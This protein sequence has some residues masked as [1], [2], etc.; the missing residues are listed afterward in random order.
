MIPDKHP[1]FRMSFTLT[2]TTIRPSMVTTHILLTKY[3][4]WSS[5]TRYIT[6]LYLYIYYI[7][8]P[9][10]TVVLRHFLQNNPL[11]LFKWTC[12]SALHTSAPSILSPHAIQPRMPSPPISCLSIPMRGITALAIRPFRDRRSF[13]RKYL[14]LLLYNTG[15]LSISSY[16]NALL[17]EHP[18]GIGPTPYTTATLV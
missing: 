6:M 9:V 11:H 18:V 10:S 17:R 16:V 1:I 5:I 4:I 2:Q 3:G 7:K 8:A 14:S 12:C 15:I 13:N